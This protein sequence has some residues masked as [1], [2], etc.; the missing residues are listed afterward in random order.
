MIERFFLPDL[1]LPIIM[2]HAR[3]KPDD[4]IRHSFLKALAHRLPV[5]SYC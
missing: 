4:M 3:L 2:H 5:P 1:S